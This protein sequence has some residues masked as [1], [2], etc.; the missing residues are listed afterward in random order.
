[1]KSRNKFYSPAV[2]LC[3]SLCRHVARKMGSTSNGKKAVFLF[4]PISLSLSVMNL[5]KVV[6]CL[7]SPPPL[8]TTAHIVVCVQAGVRCKTAG[9]LQSPELIF[10]SSK[11]W[12]PEWSEDFCTG[13]GAC[14]GSSSVTVDNLGTPGALPQWHC[15]SLASQSPWVL[16][17]GEGEQVFAAG[18]TARTEGTISLW[19]LRGQH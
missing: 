9:L 4:V 19:A 14:S 1:M 18:T 16:P 13:L 12:G 6:G 3:A 15:S 7:G 5:E 17:A 8:L 2:S 11:I 10:P